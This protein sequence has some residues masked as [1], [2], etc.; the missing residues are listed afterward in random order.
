MFAVTAL[1][2]IAFEHGREQREE[3]FF[4]HVAGVQL[5]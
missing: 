1:A 3:A 5:R 4:V 2:G